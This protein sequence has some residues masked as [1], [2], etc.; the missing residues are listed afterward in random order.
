M[1]G[2]LGGPCLEAALAGEGVE[3]GFLIWLGLLVLLI[4]ERTG[5]EELLLVMGVGEGVWEG[6]GEGKGPGDGCEG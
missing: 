6:E 2:F 3:E 4:R 1:E 5:V